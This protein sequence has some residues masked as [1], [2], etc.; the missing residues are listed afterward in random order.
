[1]LEPW[2]AGSILLP[3]CSP[4]LPARECETTLS[5]SLFLSGSTSHHLAYPGPLA[6]AEDIVLDSILQLTLKNA[7]CQGLSNAK[8]EYSHLPLGKAI[9][10]FLLFFQLLICARMD[11][12]Q[13]KQ[14]IITD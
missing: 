7:T 9:E 10:T 13:P 11:F 2:V 8:E 14:H 3:S 6:A 4:S 1:M 12:L 5:A